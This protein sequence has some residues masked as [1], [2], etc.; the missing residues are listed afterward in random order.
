MI[1]F[2]KFELNIKFNE[3]I[4]KQKKEIGTIELPQ[5]VIE[6][7][8]GKIKNILMIKISKFLSLFLSRNK[9]LKF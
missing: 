3:K 7:I 8:P 6:G 4:Y 5:A 1:I 2:L 9:L